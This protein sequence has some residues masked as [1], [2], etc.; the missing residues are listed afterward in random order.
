MFST[1][2]SVKEYT[3]YD[4]LALNALKTDKD[5]ESRALILRAQAIVEAFIGKSEIDIDSPSDLLILDKMTAYQ[6]AYMFTNEA[7]IYEQIAVT[8]QGQTDYLVN[9]NDKMMSPWIAPLAVITSNSL[10]WNKSKSVR[11][12]KIFQKQNLPTWKNY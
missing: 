12:G 2:N 8:S 10:S 5:Y 9:F 1:I 7:V 3:G 6:T 11:T 4:L